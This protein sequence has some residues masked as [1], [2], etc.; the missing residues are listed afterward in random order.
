M[1]PS[2]FNDEILFAN[3]DYDDH[4]EV[5]SAEVEKSWH[6]LIVDDDS[7]IHS[8]TK[9]ALSDLVAFNGDLKFS[10]A[11]SGKEALE[12]LK[13]HDDV[14][15]VLLD[16]VME[17]EDAG[18]QV[19][20]A[21]REDLNMQ[22]VRIVLRT[23]QPGYAPEESILKEYD[24]NDYKT[25]TELTRSKLV[26]T[27]IASLRS[28]IQVTTINQNKLG[29]EQV[30]YA[31]S[32]LLKQQSLVN[33]ADQALKQLSK[34]LNIK[35]NGL[36]CA[37]SH[38]PQAIN[39]NQMKVY[40]AT[41]DFSNLVGKQLLDC[42]N[43]RA[44]N[45]ITLALS[46]SANK[47]EEHE[48][49]IVFSANNYQAAVYFEDGRKNYSDTEKQLLDVFLTNVSAAFANLQLLNQ[50]T[51]IAYQDPLTQLPNRAQFI[52]LLNKFSRGHMEIERI[53]IIDINHFSEINDGLGQEVGDNL[54]QTVAYRISQMLSENCHLAR[55]GA[56]VFGI[57]G[58]AEVLKP[59]KLNQLFNNP[60]KAGE[61]LLP[62][63]ATIGFCDKDQAH[64]TGLNT[65]KQVYIALNRAK[66]NNQ[67]N[68]E[69]Y[70][71]EMEEQTA[72]RL[73][74]IR[75]LKSDFSNRKLEIWYQPQWNLETHTLVGVEALL[76]WPTKDG[77]YISP[78]TFIP[79]AE[80]SGLI[81]EIGAW[82]LEESC[83]QL[84]KLDNMVE[85]KIRMAVNVSMPQFRDGQF[86]ANVVDTVS[87][88]GIEPSRIELEITES[89][90]MDNPETV[91]D[92]L[93]QIKIKGIQIAI[94]DF[95]TGFSSLSYLQK[96]PLDRIKIDR[97]FINEMHKPEGAVI[98]ETIVELGKKLHLATI[99]EGVENQ[100][101][102]HRL[103]QLGCEEV[104]GFMYAKPM[105]ASELQT[106]LLQQKQKIS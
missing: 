16:V 11:Y 32:E 76:R 104:Q 103:Q 2:D 92:A 39:A 7:E 69:F 91:I 52:R 62:V 55:V 65:L 21:I 95:G 27:I 14:A 79:L 97:A 61:H 40:A 105:P 96:L 10:H 64:R 51:E 82:V 24:I 67:E 35:N 44:I 60:F 33:F 94:D 75:Q 87:R 77:G 9:L 49:I 73:G 6:V 46:D 23:G 89:I 99:A 70:S 48:T 90:V 100:D 58:D 30:I 29:L 13:E 83:R 36:F 8:V 4:E 41:E 78:A 5:A 25:K 63:S 53:A 19:V 20:K 102:E 56:D 54:L 1:C 28:Y 72:W 101:Q 22:N 38:N 85:N 68:Y 18:L 15:I 17:S 88:F 98:A 71:H 80:H 34:L 74:M 84:K 81:V 12:F 3:D 37:L 57:I 66:K 45:Q 31:S 42:D 47:L 50:V 106:L 59:E 26:T 93:N 43:G 86:V